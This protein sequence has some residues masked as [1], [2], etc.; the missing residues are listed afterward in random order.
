MPPPPRSRPT[1]V[2]LLLGGAALLGATALPS[3]VL[4]VIDPSGATMGLALQWLDRTPFPDYRI[5]GLVLSVV[6]GGGSFVVL[7]GT[8]RLRP[9][10]WRA[11]LG[12]GIGLM[13]WIVAQVLLLQQLHWLQF[14]YGTL[15][16]ALLGLASHPSVRSHLR[17]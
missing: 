15:G 3:G 8:I 14:I 4:L 13:G 10:A 1:A 7:Y 11:A 17:G 5:P 6:L 2:W 16:V 9:W 12:L